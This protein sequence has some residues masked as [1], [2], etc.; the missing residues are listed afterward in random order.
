VAVALALTVA[1]VG[2]G[3]GVVLL[4]SLL[5]VQPL[6]EGGNPTPGWSLKIHVALLVMT[7]TAVPAAAVLIAASRTGTAWVSWTALPVAAATAGLLI[8]HGA[9][10]ATR[11]LTTGQTDVLRQLTTAA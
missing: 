6:D 2:G 7:S 1:L 4:A 10:W 11:R 8:R 3:A 9:R 5:A